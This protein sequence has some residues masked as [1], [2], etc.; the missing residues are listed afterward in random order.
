MCL[1][2]PLSLSFTAVKR[3]L[4]LDALPIPRAE[5]DAERDCDRRERAARAEADVSVE[6]EAELMQRLKDCVE[7]GCEDE[8]EY[9][10]LTE[11]V[12]QVLGLTRHRRPKP[13]LTTS[14]LQT[15]YCTSQ[16]SLH[17]HRRICTEVAPPTTQHGRSAS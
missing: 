16:P 1:P 5:L 8:P 7:L 4:W 3:R 17:L 2:R 9:A 12:Q 13:A 10:V 11:Q 14:H 15:S 6:H